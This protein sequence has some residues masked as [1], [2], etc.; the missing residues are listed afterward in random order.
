MAAELQ[1]KIF[2]PFFTTKDVGKGTGLGLSTVVGIVK[3]A[4]GYIALTSHQGTGTTMRLLFPRV[5]PS[6][7][8][9]APGTVT[10][11]AGYYEDVSSALHQGGK[12]KTV[13]LVEADDSVRAIIEALLDRA[14]YR[15]VSASQPGEALLLVE[16][17]SNAPDMLIVDCIMPLMNGRGLSSRLRSTFPLLPALYLRGADL[18]SD[19]ESSGCG[20]GML[21]YYPIPE[22]VLD[23]PFREE[24]LLQ[25]VDGLLHQSR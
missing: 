24:E 15:V 6:D 13:L 3:Q 16:K 5:A 1:K 12:G 18:S 20:K 21:E 10:E 17:A 11:K 14:G 7:S 19:A 9:T 8:T 22:S 25:A 2:D 23:K 4:K